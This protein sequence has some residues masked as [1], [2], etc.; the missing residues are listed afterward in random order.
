MK[1]ENCSRDNRDIAKYCKWCGQAM[2]T[3]SNAALED[4]IGLGEIKD[5]IRLIVNTIKMLKQR[6]K[7]SGGKVSLGM[8]S[9]IIG[10]TGT[11]KTAIASVLQHLF[12]TNGIIKK[13]AAKI[14]D[15][16]DYAEF[17]GDW[18]QNVQ[19]ARGGILFID[20]AQ[21]LLPDGYSRTINELD[22]L[23]HSMDSWNN[24]PIVFLAG[25][26]KGFEEFLAQNPNIRN[27]FQYYFKLT[28]YGHLELKQICLQ[29]LENNYHLHTNPEADEKL[30]RLFKYLVKTKNE[31]F[32]NGHNASEI[33]ESIFKAYLNRMAKTGTDDNLATP[34][35]ITQYV[36]EERS[37]ESILSELEDFIGMDAVKKEVKD[38]AIQI[39]AYKD[40]AERGIGTADKPAMHFVLTGNPGTGKTTIARKLGEIFEAIGFLDSGHVIEVDRSKMVGQYTGETPKLVNELCDKAMG[41]I[42][43]VD[44][45]YTLA[46]VSTQ[47]SSDKYG[48]EA[49]ETLMKR[50]EDDRDKF[51]V[52]AAGYQK[53]MD[54]FLRANPGMKSRFNK[55]LHIDDYK[56]DELFR[57]YNIFLKKKKYQLND[58]ATETLQ[59]AIAN[60]YEMRDKDFGNGREMR[61]LFEATSAR[62]SDRISKIPPQQLSDAD[63]TTITPEDIPYEAPKTLSMEAV[64]S[65]LDGLTGLD[66]V[67]NEVRSLVQYLNL[68]KERAEAGGEKT[69]VNVH[70]VF[71]GNPGTG[72]TTVARI[73]ARVFH[74]LGIIP[75]DTLIEA[76]R[77]KLVGG[78]IGETAIKTNQL[79]DSSMGGVLFI[80]EAYTLAAGGEQDFGKEAI[81]TLLARLE[82]DRGKFIC[83]VAGYTKEMEDF[84]DSNPGMKSRFNRTIEF[85]DYKPAALATI[86]RNLVGKKGLQMDSQT[87]AWVETFFEGVYMQRDKNFGNA[88]EARKIFELALTRQSNRLAAQLS[89]PDF[90]RNQLNYLARTDIEDDSRKAKSLDEVMAGLD[91]FIGMGEV[92]ERIRELGNFI[93]LE[94]QR[95][96][97]GIGSSSLTVVHFILTGNPGTGKT[98]IARKLGEIFKALEFLPTDKVIEV[99]RAQMVSQF[100]GETP[101]LVNK[102]CDR[103]MGGIL[104]VDEAYTL[105]PVDAAGSKDKL[106][107]E[108]VEA[109]MKRMEDDRGK[110]VVIA[111]GY[112]NEMDQFAEANP[113][114]ASRFTHKIHIADYAPDELLAIFMQMTKGKNYHLPEET[115]ALAK[116]YIEELYASR[117]KNFG[118]A[119]EMRKLF[120]E[121]ANRMA[122]RLS[123]TDTASLS[124][125]DFTTV[126]P[127]DIPYEAPKTLSMDEV[128]GELNNL[129]GLDN[130]KNE[131]RSLVQYLNLEKERAEAGGEKTPVNVHFVFTGNPGT[132]KTTVARI[133]ANVFHA[134]GILPSNKLIEADRSAIVAGYIGQTAIKTNKIIDSAMGGVLFIDEAYTL[135]AGG[136]KDF[137]Q[138]AIDTLLARLENDRGKFICIAAGYTN[139]MAEFI[140]SNPGLQSRFNRT[141]E[142]E[143]YKAEALATIFRNLAAK[144][145]LQMDAETDSWLNTFFEDVYRRRDKNFGNAREA[146][147]I[148]ELALTQQS[149]RLAAQLNQADFD[150]GQLN[151]LMKEDIDKQSGTKEGKVDYTTSM[152]SLNKLIGL[153]DIKTRM[154]ALSKHLMVEKKRAEINGKQ[155]IPNMH[156]VFTG[157]PGTG[158]TTVARIIA[159]VLNGLEI[160]PKKSVIEVD[161]A[162]LVGQYIGETAIKTNK[163][164]DQAMGGV[165]FIDEAYT[166]ASG[167]KNDFGREAID[168]LLKRL[169]DDRGKFICI[170]AGYTQNMQEFIATNPG[171]ES[172]F[173]EYINFP[174]YQPNEL[175]DIFKLMAQ[176]KGMQVAEDMEQFLAEYFT[177][178]YSNRDQ[179][180]GNARTVRNIFE[181]TV[182]KQ[183]GRVA[184]QMSAP[185]FDQNEL[186]L[187]KPEDFI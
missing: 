118:N 92:K 128:M 173:N 95:I 162:A 42:L 130:V 105:T 137:G 177:Q 40:R 146:R 154:D 100:A 35:D 142:F 138:E 64:M 96:E 19:E 175:A 139:E 98:T 110:F 67:K 61:K 38:L 93:K 74:S 108:A 69:P 153:N 17:T 103:A 77:S 75:K 114:L 27:R 39:Q 126:L 46:P 70:F 185:D 72:K 101:K 60:I 28:D 158:K 25:L 119:R 148:F 116:K 41:G 15:A 12:F 33:A 11:G 90:D 120:D 156:F 161:R 84:I 54:N 79:I 171:L 8:N 63:Y 62:F 157:N 73:M 6:Q 109:L 18:E 104:F 7:A 97:K 131:V 135:A 23:F 85:E 66:N 174:D 180:F 136:E 155:M 166:L 141:I 44:E 184:E 182:Q 115:H 169:E 14:V 16:V 133:M 124:N 10:N 168:T 1:C 88:R 176:G 71:T 143:D 86:F 121:T 129:T 160:L 78:Y 37:L 24:D 36:P 151:I 22:K 2:L 179:N 150:R 112:K 122:T 163:L 140:S 76:D 59:K 144:K 113:G 186:L 4:L 91:E 58:A 50:M 53:E 56:P 43:F 183:S 165:L 102:L 145:G 26:P 80:D 167:G 125:E 159:E 81:D 111:A 149:N 34:E 47:G 3:K 178:V 181:K 172:R 48:Q 147:K 31:S 187:L 89:S 107:Q 127:E 65:E 106:G 45:A 170:I 87:D 13:P 94:K 29:K 82:N 20:N 123:K 55:Y 52:I 30:N 164:I 9:L 68:E 5:E 132:G 32:G 83:I 152:A 21:K 117:D 57:I 99:D 49:I 134:L 51:V